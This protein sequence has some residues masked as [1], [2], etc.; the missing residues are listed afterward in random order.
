MGRDLS[1]ARGVARKASLAGFMFIMLFGGAGATTSGGAAVSPEAAIHAAMAQVC[2]PYVLEGD[3][4]KSRADALATAAGFRPVAPDEALASVGE[5]YVALGLSDAAARVMI[6][7]NL[8]RG[9]RDCGVAVMNAPAAFD[10]YLDRLLAS[11]WKLAGPPIPGR[12]E[13]TEWIWS[14]DS[15]MTVVATRLNGKSDVPPQRVLALWIT[16]GKQEIPPPC[17]P[18]QSPPCRIY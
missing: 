4:T 6:D 18:H 13:R 12:G 10:S 9:D 3:A 5:D 2:Q 16:K 15:A 14:P 1:K 7:F 8:E 11:G 17:G